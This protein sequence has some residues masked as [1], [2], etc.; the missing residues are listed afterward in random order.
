MLGTS[1]KIPGHAPGV[2]LEV[3]AVWPVVSREH[4]T[5]KAFFTDSSLEWPSFC[6][7]PCQVHAGTVFPASPG[8][9]SLANDGCWALLGMG[10]YWL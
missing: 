4:G 9:P 6:C 10:S 5:R 3:G 8:W 1:K 2:S 7:R